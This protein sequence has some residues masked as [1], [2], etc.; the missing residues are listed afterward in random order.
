MW[1]TRPLVGRAWRT[2]KGGRAVT[3]CIPR[4]C[5]CP[6]YLRLLILSS[7][8]LPRLF[9]QAATSRPRRCHSASRYLLSPARILTS[10][11]PPTPRRPLPSPTRHPSHR[12]S[13]LPKPSFPL[14]STPHP[15][16]TPTPCPL[17]PPPPP[18][19][20]PPPPRQAPTYP[21]PPPP[22]A[23][24]APSSTPSP[25]TGTSLAAAAP[26]TPATCTAPSRSSAS[27]S[28]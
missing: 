19:L 12:P 9:I 5:E 8:R 7:S 6:R 20:P 3:R 4:R 27:T 14:P 16:F 25:T 18:P 24:P 13:S 15:P 17:P 22:P 28:P 2:Y 10:S 1:C 11:T 23:P 26:S 21:P